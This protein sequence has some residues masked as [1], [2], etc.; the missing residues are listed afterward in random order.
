[1]DHTVASVAPPR[2]ITRQPG[3]AARTWSGSGTGIQSPDSSA[4]RSGRGVP[5]A[6]SGNSGASCCRAAGA[7]SQ[8]VIGSVHSRRT[9]S[10][11]SRS[12]ASEAMCTVPPAARTPKMSHTDR[13]KASE[14]T[15]SRRSAGPTPSVRL[16]Q[17]I[18]LIAGACCT[19][20]PFGRPVEPEVWMM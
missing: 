1:L 18:R 15:K 10:A 14:V 2:L 4:S 7:E 12:A 5:A 20:I 19:A 13:S 16:T 3:K 11:G 9:S 6:A 17:W 8:S